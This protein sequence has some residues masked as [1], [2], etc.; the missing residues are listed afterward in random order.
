MNFLNSELEH[1][2]T[3]IVNAWNELKAEENLTVLYF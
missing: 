2:T 1:T 3:E